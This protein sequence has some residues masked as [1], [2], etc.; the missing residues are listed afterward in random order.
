MPKKSIDQIVLEFPSEKKPKDQTTKQEQK[1]NI[2]YLQDL[3]SVLNPKSN[4]EIDENLLIQDMK[5]AEKD[6]AYL[7]YYYTALVLNK[8]F[9]NYQKA[10]YQKALKTEEAKR[11]EREKD[12]LVAAIMLD[13][14]NRNANIDEKTELMETLFPEDK[15]GYLT[16]TKKPGEK[17]YKIIISYMKKNKFE[18]WD[19]A[20]NYGLIEELKNSNF[21]KLIVKYKQRKKQLL[22]LK[23]HPNSSAPS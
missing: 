20:L 13:Y 10:N 5:K 19:I 9:P 22:K 18:E 2:N 23:N 21:T 4:K 15:R 7:R 11:G 12:L 17:F 3:T 14:K 1:Y 8:L 16:Q 6:K